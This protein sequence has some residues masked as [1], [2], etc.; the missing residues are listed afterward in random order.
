M[1]AIAVATAGKI[2]IVESIQQK[3]LPASEAILAGAP[4]RIHTDGKWTNSNGTTAGEA[5]VWGIATRSVI[6]GEAMT[7]VRRGTLGGFT[8]SQAYDAP[9]YLS[10]TDGTLADVAGTVST[11]VG[12]VVPGT[13]VTVGTAFDKLLSVEL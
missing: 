9:I 13:A 11:V 12:R 4:V 1:A 2:H 5:R 8:F 6:A 10:D 7:A 3:S